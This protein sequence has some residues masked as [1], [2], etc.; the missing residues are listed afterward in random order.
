MD[1]IVHGIL[2][3]RMPEWVAIPFSRGSSQPR[4]QTQV[5]HIAGRFCI[6]AEPRNAQVDSLSLLQ[7]VFPTQDSNQGHLHCSWILYQLSYEESLRYITLTVLQRRLLKVDRL[8][9]YH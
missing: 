7:Q 2:Q 4:D 9:T 6:P 8:E 5:S 3:A 1:Y